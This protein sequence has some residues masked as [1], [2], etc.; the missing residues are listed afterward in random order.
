MYTIETIL[1]KHGL[2]LTAPRRRVFESLKLANHPLSHAELIAMN[3]IVDRVSIYRIVALFIEIGVAVAVPHGWKQRYELAAPFRPHHHHLQ[4][5]AC[6][7]IEDIQSSE[8]EKII[9]AIAAQ[10]TFHI[11]SH[12]FEISGFCSNCKKLDDPS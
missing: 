2:R 4:C 8:L 3:S 9:Q 12:S 5:V 6:G 10:R 11:T 7:R 1:S